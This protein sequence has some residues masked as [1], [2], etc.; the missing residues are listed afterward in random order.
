MQ[1]DNII[2]IQKDGVTEAWG[3]LTDMCGVDMPGGKIIRNGRNH[4][5]FSYNTLKSWKYPYTYKGWRF[6][7]IPFRTMAQDMPDY[8]QVED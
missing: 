3:S 7:K 6:I 5:E 4:Q 1:R 2:I 8:S